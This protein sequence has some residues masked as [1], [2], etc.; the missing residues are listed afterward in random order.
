MTPPILIRF[1]QAVTAKNDGQLV[2]V[3]GQLP[4]L[5]AKTQ[6]S[7]NLLGHEFLE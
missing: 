4:R 7:F 6:W 3:K 2:A 5:V 1:G